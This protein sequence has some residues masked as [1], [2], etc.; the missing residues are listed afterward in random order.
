MTAL[1]F[2]AR[3]GAVAGAIDG[4]ACLQ[5]LSRQMDE[6]LAGRGKIPML[7]SDLSA[8]IAVPEGAVCAVLDAGGTN[9]RT[10][11]AVWDGNACLIGAARAAWAEKM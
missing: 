8:K 9:L 6:G 3:W 1:E 7:P 11:R 10:A 4:K 2:M 5:A